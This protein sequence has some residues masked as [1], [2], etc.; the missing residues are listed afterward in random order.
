MSG[1]DLLKGKLKDWQERFNGNDVHSIRLQVA[2]ML[3]R[4]AFYRSVNESRK[5]LA[6]DED[7]E[8]QANG[9]LH[10]L[11]DE[12]Y[13]TMHVAAIRRLVDRGQSS[14]PK[15]VNSLYGL[16]KDIKDSAALLTRANTLA[17]RELEYDFEPI[18]E[19]AFEDGRGK[20][21]VSRAGWFES[22]WWHSA[23]DKLSGVIQPNRDPNDAPT[24]ESFERLLEQLALHGRNV[25]DYGDK[26]VAHAA[27]PES[28]ATLHPEDQSLSLAKLW[29]AERVV[30]R[31]V[32]FISLYVLNGH[33][34]GGVP[35]PQFDQFEHLE[36]PFV[37][38][39]AFD[40]M[41]K[42]WD[43]HSKEIRACN[44]WFWDRPLA[45]GTDV[46]AEVPEDG[47]ESSSD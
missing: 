4:S 47:T 11:I 36:K 42:Q 9:M 24:S 7:G 23:L 30:I 18:K 39:E 28:R 45:D 38:S 19:R 31:L 21:G 16:V 15:G 10:R 14:G 35:I 2:T 40:V 25:Q 20:G 32:S 44:D 27:L 26:H 1:A 41:K 33:S 5:F 43:L 29:L 17:A 22:E 12:G 46:W 6:E 8:K 3:S 34:F 13:L 37:A